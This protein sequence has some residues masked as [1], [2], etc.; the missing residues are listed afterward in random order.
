LSFPRPTGGCVTWKADHRGERRL[1][2]CRILVVEDEPLVALEISDLLADEGAEVIGPAMDL[3]ASVEL[4]RR[5]SISAAVLDVRLS[6]GA[7]APVA[8]I[9]SERGI[10][11]IFYTG[12]A[13]T[14]A[15]RLEWPSAPVIA[16]PAP[17]RNLV[18][19]IASLHPP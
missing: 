3:G 7:V 11:F 2:K 5:A 18:A 6:D 15:V 13:E 17:A 1:R 8:R 10:P 19:A 4:A 14:D 9:L 12:Q 16:K